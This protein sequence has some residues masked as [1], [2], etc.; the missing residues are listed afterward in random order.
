M[1]V[2][3]GAE[4]SQKLTCPAVT[5][6]LPTLTVAVRSTAVPGVTLVTAAPPD[7]KLK[8]VEVAGRRPLIGIELEALDRY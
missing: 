8:V 7:V 5:G 1:S 3:C 4:A 6:A 2:Q